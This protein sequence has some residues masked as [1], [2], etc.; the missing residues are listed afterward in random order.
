MQDEGTGPAGEG[1]EVATAARPAGPAAVAI[2]A[3]I[4]A[5]LLFSVG[6]SALVLTAGR[7]AA[8]EEETPTEAPTSAPA[9]AAAGATTA[10]TGRVRVIGTAGRSRPIAGG[11]EHEVTFSWT[12]EGAQE[13]DPVVLQVHAG[14]RALGQQRGTLDPSVF[15]FSTGT[16]TVV[17]TLECSTAGW[18]GEILTIR[19]QPIEGDSEAVVAGPACR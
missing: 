10:P 18:I 17:T 14:T 7:V 11:A 8:V 2:F 9:R 3:G 12:L 13:N 6:G 1:G 15:S 16:L 4:L 19:D 5:L